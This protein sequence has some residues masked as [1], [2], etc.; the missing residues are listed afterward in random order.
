M[1]PHRS[2][3]YEQKDY[4]HSVL[5]TNL[6]PDSTTFSIGIQISSEHEGPLDTNDS[7]VSLPKIF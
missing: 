2:A 4:R 6:S 5:V 1:A 3:S 7:P